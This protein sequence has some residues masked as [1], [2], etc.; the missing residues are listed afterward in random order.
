MTPFLPGLLLG[1][2]GSAHCAAMCGPL[3][4]TVRP[5]SPKRTQL[6]LYHG[7]RVLVYL[8]LALAAGLTGHLLSFSGFGRTVSVASGVTLLALAAGSGARLISGRAGLFWSV[9]LTR[10]CV[11]ANRSTRAH[12]I[13]GQLL[14]GMVN[15]LLPCGLVYAAAIAAA[16][17]GNVSSAVVF[18]A[19]FGFGTIPVLALISLSAASVPLAL[20]ARLRRLAPAALVLTG[21]LLIVRGLRAHHLSSE[22]GSAPRA[23]SHNH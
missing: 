9:T 3:V 15:G 21:M 18:M 16:G 5:A 7:G 8:M 12:P 14:T 1:L 11:A 4:L 2:A 23:V 20:R 10:L 17:F 22:H 19:G 13:T 6:L